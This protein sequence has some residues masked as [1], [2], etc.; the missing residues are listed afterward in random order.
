[1]EEI[2]LMVVQEVLSI[3]ET[4]LLVMMDQ[5]TKET[6]VIKEQEVVSHQVVP[7]VKTELVVLLQVNK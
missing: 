2:L 1:M 4:A 3:M 6:K 7:V 5:E